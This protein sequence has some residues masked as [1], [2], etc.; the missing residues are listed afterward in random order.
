MTANELIKMIDTSGDLEF[1]L[2]EKKYTILCWYHEGPNVAEQVTEDNQRVFP[3]GKALVNGYIIN[4]KPLASQ[5]N[6]FKIIS[7]N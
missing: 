1:S 7:V 4:G 5:M 3:D 6:D 2:R